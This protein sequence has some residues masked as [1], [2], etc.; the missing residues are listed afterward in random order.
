MPGDAQPFPVP[1][2]DHLSDLSILGAATIS[3]SGSVGLTEGDLG[4]IRTSIVARAEEARGD[5][6]EGPKGLN[7][8]DKAFSE[9]SCTVMMHFDQEPGCADAYQNGRRD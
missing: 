7:G 6:H 8:C 3:R 5:D 4:S 2:R 1:M 9:T